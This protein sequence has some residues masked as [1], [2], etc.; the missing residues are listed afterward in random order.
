MTF[1]PE[2]LFHGGGQTSIK[3]V[4]MHTSGE[5]ARIIYSGWPQMEGT[6]LEQRREAMTKYDH[7]RSRVIQEPRGH[8]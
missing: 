8:E 2:L 4:D 6:L 7:L 5:P 3:T 1:D